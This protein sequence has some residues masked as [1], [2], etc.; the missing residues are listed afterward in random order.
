MSLTNVWCWE[1][2]NTEYTRDFTVARCNE[3]AEVVVWFLGGKSF[4]SSDD[5]SHRV[6]DALTPATSDLSQQP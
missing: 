4:R 1:K 6:E 2:V 5:T 3:V